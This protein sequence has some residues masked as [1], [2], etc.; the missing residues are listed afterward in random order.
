MIKTRNYRKFTEL[1]M[2]W[3][4]KE[5]RRSMPW[6]EEKNPYKIWLSEI[7]L[8]QT[9]VEQ[10]SAYFLRF[11]KNYPTVHD[12]AAAPADDVFK[13]WEGLGYYSRCKNLIAS[14]KFI[15]GEFKGIF[16]GN[17]HDILQLK[18]IGPYT[19]AA[20]ASF[21][22]NAPHAV[23]DGNVNRVLAR[24]FGINT[25]IDS[26]R[27]KVE[28]MKLANNLLPKGLSALF[29]QALMDFGATICKPKIPLCNTCILE[30]HCSAFLNDKVDSLPVKEK[31]LVKKNRWFYY[32]IVS[33]KDLY[34]INKRT[35][36]GIWQNLYEFYLVERN[37][38]LP[39]EEIID[40][41][42]IEIFKGKGFRFLNASPCMRQQLT[43]QT[44]H[45]SFISIAIGKK[46][47]GPAGEWV[48]KADID[49]LAFPRMINEFM[50]KAF[51]DKMD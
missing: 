24:Y 35:A 39:L 48:T 42:E 14:A 31:S 45:A 50:R 27:G 8:Q 25:P 38:Q 46:V 13:L 26:A 23:V 43:H 12:L 28:F 33:Y 30:K 36:K 16:P 1:L 19:A 2:Q 7:I 21:A 49:R 5:N 15:A 11:I 22:Y 34:L 32:F 6:K 40:F 9:R 29:N 10:G 41:P 37:G 51:V 17:Y 3:H 20:I 44:I 18:G 4:L 47:G